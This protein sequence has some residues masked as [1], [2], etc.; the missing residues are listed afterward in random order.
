MHGHGL[1]V[2]GT[3][4]QGEVRDGD[5]L[6]C[7]P[8]GHVYRVRSVQVHGEPV[9]A[10]GW[11]QRIALNLPDADRSSIERGH[12]LCDE[13]LNLT[14]DR[15]DARL[16]VR[17][18][19]SAAIENHQRVRVHLGTTERRAKVILLGTAETVEPGQSAFCQLLLAEPISALR[20]D[21]FV[22]RDETGQHTLGGGVIIHPS[23]RLHRRRESDL[24]ARLEVLEAGNTARIAEVFLDEQDEFASPMTSL[25]QFLNL[26]ADDVIDRLDG[27]PAIRT[28]ALD[29]EHF[30]TTSRKWDA[31][32]DTLVS[33]LRAAHS[34]DPLAA[35]KEMEELREKLPGRVPPKLYRSWLES[36]EHESAIVRDGSLLRLPEHRVTLRDE[37]GQA[38]ERILTLLAQS[39]LAPPDLAEMS[40]QAGIERSTLAQVLRVLERERSVARVTSELYF[41]TDTLEGLKRLVREEFPEGAEI[42]PAAFRDRL[43][44]TR[45]HAIPLLEY[46]DRQGI[47]VRLANTRRVKAS[48]S[49]VS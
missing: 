6:C 3:A 42:T 49:P 15:C 17:P 9:S 47:T 40:R 41:L 30:F 25:Q 7:L 38:A 19:A 10:A 13:R 5:R 23:P 31:L 48:R 36:I 20:G 32:R 24:E 27:S 21:R 28:M 18:S 34:A 46:L 16:E 11:G 1:V 2:T 29:G 37:A 43:A 14:S 4:L 33:S 22:I 8:G 35:G 12:V 44:I 45:K 26:R 39:P